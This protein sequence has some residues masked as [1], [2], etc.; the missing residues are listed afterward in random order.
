MKWDQLKPTLNGE[1]KVH[2]RS[3]GGVIELKCKRCLDP[4]AGYRVKAYFTS[5]NDL[6]IWWEWHRRSWQHT[7]SDESFI[8]LREQLAQ[9]SLPP[10]RRE[11]LLAE[12][13]RAVPGYERP[14]G[15]QAILGFHSFVDSTL[16]DGYLGCVIC[17][18]HRPTH[19]DFGDTPGS[20]P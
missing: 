17:G 14:A 18:Q 4:Q 7:T 19:H 6:H 16:I 3:T 5:L 12:F 8:L 20:N 1:A 13:Q 15:W 2:A 9:H 11:T 10:D